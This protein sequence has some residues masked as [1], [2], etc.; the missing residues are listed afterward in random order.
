M[1]MHGDIQHG[2][3]VVWCQ[4]CSSEFAGARIVARVVDD[5]RLAPAE[6]RKVRGVETLLELAARGVTVEGAFVKVEAAD[7]R[8]TLAVAPERNALDVHETGSR[9]GH[10]LQ[11]LLQIL[12]VE[13]VAAH[14]RDERRLLFQQML[15]PET[16]RGQSC[17]CVHVVFRE[18]EERPALPLARTK[19]DPAKLTTLARRISR[20]YQ[21][22]P[23]LLCGYPYKCAAFVP[24][25][26]PAPGFGFRNT[27]STNEIQSR[28]REEE[29]ERT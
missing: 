12:P 19:R 25:P 5:D 22:I 6:R 2:S 20:G 28:D 4:V 14:E 10:R 23:I 15:A 8:P 16:K 27:G 18:F 29:R 24:A 7:R 9:L 1:Q 3:D 26:P 17:A 13:D 21:E 11:G